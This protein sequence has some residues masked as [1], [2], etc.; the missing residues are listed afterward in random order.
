MVNTAKS[1]FDE[2]RGIHE[3]RLGVLK[4]L[5]AEGV[6][7]ENITVWPEFIG[8]REVALARAQGYLRD[9]ERLGPDAFERAFRGDPKAFRR[10]R[11]ALEGYET[12]L[13]E[14]DDMMR[15][16]TVERLNVT[17]PQAFDPSSVHTG[18]PRVSEVLE[19]P[20]DDVARM[21]ELMLDPARR[22]AYER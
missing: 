4:Q 19:M 20:A 7:Q 10:Y 15:P 11:A 18:W 13:H 2:L 22:E 3:Q 6:L 1:K 21:N 14:L 8:R 12:A 17:E 5:E 16:R 9:L